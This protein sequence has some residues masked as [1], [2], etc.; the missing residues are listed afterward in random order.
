MMLTKKEYYIVSSDKS[1]RFTLTNDKVVL[2]TVGV[3]RHGV[4]PCFMG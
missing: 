2:N 3:C 4:N 1:Q